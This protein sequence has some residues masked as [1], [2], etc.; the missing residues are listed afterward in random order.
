LIYFQDEEYRNNILSMT[1][2]HET[3]Q[4]IMYLAQQG[5]D[6]VFLV[7]MEHFGSD[8][9]VQLFENVIIKALVFPF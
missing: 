8:R 2:K 3:E 6:G 1:L 4:A 5:V 9:F 7:G